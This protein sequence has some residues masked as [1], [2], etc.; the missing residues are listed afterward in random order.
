M[1]TLLPIW[2]QLPTVAQVSTMLPS[3]IR[4]PMLTKLG[5]STAP[6]AINEPRRTIAPGTARNA[7]ASN[8]FSPQPAN[9]DGTLSHQWAPPGAPDI[10]SIEFNR[11][12]S[13]T[14]FLSH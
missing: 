13:S 6:G 8:S 10:A 11:N 9:F 4:A 12:D 7:A 14:A 1:W 3:P 5:I 2:A